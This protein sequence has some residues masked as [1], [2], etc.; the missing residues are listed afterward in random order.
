MLLP[1][2]LL[3]TGINLF[4]IILSAG[5]LAEGC[6]SFKQVESCNFETDE[7][8]GFTKT[9]LQGEIISRDKDDWRISPRYA[10]NVLVNPASPNPARTNLISLSITIYDLAGET[11]T[12]LDIIARDTNGNWVSLIPAIGR[13]KTTPG[14]G[15]WI[16]PADL[17]RLSSQ[18]TLGSVAGLHRIYL[19]KFPMATDFCNDLIS[20][21]DIYI[22]P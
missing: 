7:I 17:T 9:N 11:L 10:L 3:K 2:T 4:F 16:L 15:T 13:P 19:V 21:G 5:L 12:D 22:L 18:G 6:E 20:Y 1:V 8:S 14:T